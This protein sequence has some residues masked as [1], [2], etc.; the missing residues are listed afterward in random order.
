MSDYER[1]EPRAALERLF[2]QARIARDV[3]NAANADPDERAKAVRY[4]VALY[5][6]HSTQNETERAE[7]ESL[8][9]NAGISPLSFYLREFALDIGHAI[10]VSP[11]PIAEL[12]RI[13]NGTA[14]LGP[15]ERPFE[16]RIEIAAHV[17]KLRFEGVTLE[18]ACEKVAETTRNPHIGGVAVRRIYENA[19]KEDLALVRAI[20]AGT[21]E[22]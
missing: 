6:L 2:W 18:N 14:K 3:L 7:L 10:L 17:E 1:H 9:A 21:V 11:N 12:S 16:R 20:A 15:K 13:L 5:R 4:W 8:A 22:F 19:V